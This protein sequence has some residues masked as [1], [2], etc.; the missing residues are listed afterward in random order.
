MTPVSV[1]FRSMHLVPSNST[2]KPWCAEAE[3]AHPRRQHVATTAPAT[4]ILIAFFLPLEDIGLIDCGLYTPKSRTLSRR[5]SRRLR[6]PRRR[7]RELRRRDAHV[8]LDLAELDRRAAVGPG[9]HSLER[10]FHAGDVA[11]I[12][13]VDLRRDDADRGVDEAHLPHEQP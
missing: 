6:L 7:F 13:I 4:L 9:N 1:P 10:H 11:V 8:R 3:P 2:L 5:R 12:G